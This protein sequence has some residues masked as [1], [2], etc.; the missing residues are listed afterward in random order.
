MGIPLYV[1]AACLR[2]RFAVAG[3]ALCAVAAGLR[4]VAVTL[5]PLAAAAV[6]FTVDRVLVPAEEDF[7]EVRANVFRAS[8]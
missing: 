6:C 4:A 8:P 2:V 5:P 7:A 1:L 3:V